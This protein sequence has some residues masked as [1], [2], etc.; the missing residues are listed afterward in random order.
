ME[1]T[2]PRVWSPRPSGDRSTRRG[3]QP[4]TSPSNDHQREHPL[5][6]TPTQGVNTM[7]KIL[8]R[9]VALLIVGVT[10]L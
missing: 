8:A 10:V 2:Q 3:V 6:G 5:P 1:L 4:M 9:V 7:S